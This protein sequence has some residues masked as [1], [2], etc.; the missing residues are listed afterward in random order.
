MKNRK[1]TQVFASIVSVVLLCT[2]LVG[3][4]APIT[5][6]AAN[7]PTLTSTGAGQ[8]SSNT[9]KGNGT[10]TPKNP[11]KNVTTTFTLKQNRAQGQ[12]RALNNNGKVKNTPQPNT[13]VTNQNNQPQNPPAQGGTGS[14]GATT[15]PQKES[16]K[17]KLAAK[18]TKDHLKEFAAEQA[19]TWVS[20][21][22]DIIDSIIKV[23]KGEEEI[24]WAKVGVAAAKLVVKGIAAYFGC[25]EIAGA[26]VDGLEK[27]LTRGDTPLSEMD[28]LTDM[29]GQEFNGM[30]DKLYE[31][32][33]EIASISNQI[34]ASV[35]E[36]LS[37]TQS[38][39][40][41]VEAKEILRKFMSSGEGNFS[42]NELT[43]YLYG[44]NNNTS[45]S[46]EAYYNLLMRSINNNEPDEVTK[47]YYDKLFESL[48]NSLPI[49]NEYFYGKVAGLDK[50]IACYYYD[51]LSANPDLVPKG[52]T[53]EYEAIQFAYDLQTTYLYS[54][55]LINQ[56]YAYQITDM[57]FRYLVDGEVA[58][59]NN[60][61]YQYNDTD[62]ITYAEILAD[63][64]KIQ[65]YIDE[66]EV[67]MVKD[68]NY[69]LG[70]GDSY[71]V[72]EADGTYR[73]AA[74]NAATFGNLLD[75]QT[76]YLNV[77]NEE[78]LDL[79]SLERY[80]F[81][82]Y[83][84]DARISNPA[85]LATIKV[86]DVD[87]DYF[88]VS[89]K[90]LTTE[91]YRI[92]FEKNVTYDFAGGNGSAEDPYIIANAD[93]VSFVSNNL[94]ACYKLINDIDFEGRS[95]IYTFGS[96]D[97]SYNGT[98]DGN[99]HTI[100]NIEIRSNL[101]DE[102]NVTMAPSTGLFGSIGKD[103]VVQNLTL[104]NVTVKALA[105]EDGIGLENDNSYFNVGIIAGVNGGKIVNCTISGS[106]SLK[107]DR[108]KSKSSNRCLEVRVGGI[109]GQNN[110]IVSYCT[111]DGV[112]IS[113]DT[114]KF[115]YGA[116]DSAVNK[117][118]LY[119]GGIAGRSNG[120]ISNSR[121]SKNTTIRAYASNVANTSEKA[122]PYLT[123]YAGGIVGDP[124]AKNNLSSV[125]SEC[126]DIISGGYVFN[127]GR[128][129]GVHRLS[130]ANCSVKQGNYYPMYAYYDGSTDEL[131]AWE[132]KY[133]D[134]K[135]DRKKEGI[136][137]DCEE[138]KALKE[139]EA[140][141]VAAPSYDHESFTYQEAEYFTFLIAD[142]VEYKAG[143]DYIMFKT[144]HVLDISGQEV[145]AS[146]LGSYG[147]D[148]SNPSF[149]ETRTIETTIFYT[150]Q[151]NGKTLLKAG[152][153]ELT[154]GVNE[155]I[156]AEISGFMSTPLNINAS[157]EDCLDAI[158]ADEFDFVN[159]YANGE[160]IAV[161]VTADNRDEFVITDIDTSAFGEIDITVAHGDVE[162]GV[163]LKVSCA[164]PNGV[165]FKES[166]GAT[167][168]LMGYDVY[169]CA[170]CGYFYHKNYHEGTHTY[171]VVDGSEATCHEPGYTQ[172][173]M[174]SICN[175]VFESSEWI[176]ALPHDY[177]TIDEA[178]EAVLD[179]IQNDA[180]VN[181]DYHY[182]VNGDHYEPHQY[183]V[184]ESSST[185]GKMIYI[186]TCVTCGYVS[187][188]IDE[189]IT[190]TE[191]GEIPVVFITDGYV[192]NV[193][194][195]VVVYVQILNNP[196]FNGANF[197]IRY[198]DGLE[199]IGFEE[200]TIVPAQL[201]VNNEV[202]NGYNFLWA[203]GS[204]NSEGDG[205][206]LKLT[207]KYVSE[208]GAKQTIDVVYGMQ[209]EQDEYGDD[210]D[211]LGGFT[212]TTDK[213]V[214]S[215]F[216]THSGTISLVEHLPGDVNSD[217]EVDIMDAT[218]IAWS[219]VGKTDSQGNKITVEKR[220][221]DVNLDGKVDLND[222]IAVLQSV[223]GCYGTNLLN[224][225]YKL[226]LN[227]AGYTN[228]NIQTSVDINYYNEDG[229]R[230]KW[231]DNVDF[232]AVKAQMNR[233]GYTFVGW[234]TR[235]EGGT[236]VDTSGN[237][238]FDDM[239]GVQTLYARWAKNKVVFDMSGS[240]DEAF[241][242]V[243]YT[244]A[245]P[246]VTPDA[247]TWS[248]D[249]DY[250][251]ENYGIYGDST[252]K[253]YKNFLG[254]Y[255]GDTLVSEYD[256]STPNLGT[257]TLVAKW[258]DTYNWQKPT[259]TRAGYAD[260][261]NWYY[262]QAYNST[263][264]IDVVDDA[265]IEELKKTGFTIYGQQNIIK[266]FITYENLK[267][268]TNA[269]NDYF[270]VTS[271]ITLTNLESVTGYEFAGWYDASGNKIIKINEKT[272]DM[273]LVA[274]WN[275]KVYEITVKGTD[276]NNFT[277]SSNS[278]LYSATD[279]D[280]FTLYYRYDDRYYL[281]P[282]C[283]NAIPAN[284]FS[285]YC[286]QQPGYSN[287]TIDGIYSAMITNNAHSNASVASSALVMNA[288]TSSVRM[289]E[290]NE[291]NRKGTL[292]A[293]LTPKKYTITF[294]HAGQNLIDN[295]LRSGTWE[296]GNNLKI[297]Y[298]A[299]SGIYTLTNIA[300]SDPHVGINQ[301]V[302]L[303]AGVQYTM[304]MDIKSSGSANSIQVFYAIND[305]YTEA[306]S[307]RF[308]GSQSV[309]FTVPTS[310]RYNL[311]IDNDCGGT[312]TISNFWVSKTRTERVSVYYNENPGNITIPT[313]LFYNFAGYKYD[314]S[315]VYYN[316]NG[317][318]QQPYAVSGDATFVAQWTQK[319]SGT[320]IK[321][322][323]EFRN[324]KK[325][326]SGT[327]YL[328][329]DIDLLKEHFTPIENFTG[330]IDG[331]GHTLHGLSYEFVGTSG[332]YTNFGMFRQ[333]SGNMRNL[334]IYAPYVY[335]EK[336]KDGRDNDSTGVIAGKMNGGTISNVSIIG[337]Y[338]YGS[339][340]RDVVDGG[341]Y[342]NAYVGGFVGYMVGGTISNCSISNS[343]IRSKATGP[344]KSAD[345]HA[346][347]GGI[348]GYMTAGTV[349]NCSR[350]DSTLVNA[351]GEQNSGE[352]TPNSAIRAAAGGL[353]GSRDGGTVRG[354]S[355][356][357]NLASS[358]VT[359]KDASNYSWARK[360]AIVGTGGQ[361]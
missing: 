156:G 296:S 277:I 36:I 278:A 182:C 67:Q 177:I 76:I 16:L 3:F 256:L 320:Y 354:T 211:N 136:K 293:K 210:V 341:T 31:I 71:L 122:N 65:Q 279:R 353:V 189:N 253:L 262:K 45:R 60:S 232:E 216:M 325:N 114:N 56:C 276:V 46:N 310:G 83:I 64:A 69:I 316:S 176:Q 55:N 352:K 204:G 52:S 148:S 346:F 123:C 347:A 146:F 74:N 19:A 252:Y 100:S 97:A 242:D 234:Y 178:I 206:L 270:F 317:I 309:N 63:V 22:F 163:K 151:Y 72:L 166:V 266:Y 142:T 53:A 240:N 96:T 21:T 255:I 2:F 184:S 41:N 356:A 190:T 164:H 180:Y 108:T 299:A 267:G 111:V 34:T 157:E 313:G 30:N 125:Y 196:G 350:A 44:N 10:T 75:G 126:S 117:N 265:M 7:D 89:V 318:A 120:Q 193:G 54:Y 104:K 274:R 24:D 324:I 260:I 207:F 183:V 226:I 40:N 58:L 340:H 250:I 119:V 172:S 14:T 121:V 280:L 161:H 305:A 269:N 155:I 160:K 80:N 359:G 337:A 202:Y 68:L 179:Y 153:V 17:D 171:V 66:A 130:T 244:D 345:G 109:T 192:V 61:Y 261:T 303:E 219:I 90:Y 33:A 233:L 135:K 194:D 218:I 205:Y 115:E 217:G 158:F 213:N 132:E 39:I 38:Q 13:T 50:S 246:T 308:S 237:I 107:F 289:P 288:D 181:K 355:S 321:T 258:S 201:R 275:P 245:A 241:D 87:K 331:L 9:A 118:A 215:R 168:R 79:F 224:S 73:E 140:Q 225:E 292:Y 323:E 273:T 290:L 203:S 249:V 259:E 334:T 116:N 291:A 25:G 209:E 57:S 238:S 361:G 297:A 170:D 239:Q 101:Q 174:C 343:E 27:V 103:G 147:F 188:V 257:V 93:Q 349:S 360:D 339:H 133:Y 285:N 5:A 319:Y 28:K 230:S 110:G 251:V 338:V 322:Q 357:N 167:C 82:Y 94:D 333:F 8:T 332:D 134:T 335:S 254:W 198:T 149:T 91:I 138:T 358:I 139:P 295:A 175:T 223:S 236:L 128:Y 6:Y 200:S 264:L 23:C 95:Y 342:S 247:P 220:Y 315:V 229:T 11:Q 106:S 348:V 47:Y 124:D 235:L 281:E 300:A 70:M 243:V 88:V 329:C 212:S 169:E 26:I 51:Y 150:V 304:H 306:N 127:E 195:E 159:Y 144:L 62:R 312:A 12:L 173:V 42:Y 48:Y 113:A 59:S 143:S 314:G 272:G 185:E 162:V 197:G 165:A 199:L 105:S 35:N 351:R 92:V 20:G 248:Y 85:E 154:I 221:A 222:V 29:L 86:D 301:W 330:T 49:Y 271:D 1:W 15:T 131:V 77:F 129:W 186:Y 98:F 328:V 43:N 32:E 227:L 326:T 231:N 311:R 228:G 268:A 37:G 286:V 78:I 294:D 302:T 298:D 84:D 336:S 307:L 18:M 191:G 344:L 141:S 284:Y 263:Y 102:T 152:T 208:D 4:A 327:Y 287:F 214:I 283:A 137:E 145:E 112:S 81:T 99:G 282:N 187:E